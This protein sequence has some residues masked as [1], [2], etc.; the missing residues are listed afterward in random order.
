MAEWDGN[1][2][3]KGEPALTKAPK[4]TFNPFVNRTPELASLEWLKVGCFVQ[5]SKLNGS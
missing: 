3:T 2:G 1:K 4:L 5:G